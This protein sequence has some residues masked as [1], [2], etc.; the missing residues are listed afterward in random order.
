MP[1]TIAELVNSANSSPGNASITGAV[2]VTT[3][4]SDIEHEPSLTV[5]KEFTFRTYL[6]A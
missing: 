1:I 5:A 4:A 2:V 6:R 3:R